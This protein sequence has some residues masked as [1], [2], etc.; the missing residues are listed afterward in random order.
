[1]ATS[2]AEKKKE[3]EAKK[4]LDIPQSILAGINAVAKGLG[5]AAVELWGIF[6]RQYFVKG[7]TEAFTAVSLGIFAWALHGTIGWWALI[8]ATVAHM[9]A[10]GAIMLLGNPKYYAIEDIAGKIEEFRKSDAM[11]KEFERYKGR[12]Y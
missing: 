10:Y 1:M 8:P 7:L 2:E 3:E 4:A 11:Y 5:V 12:N 9:F 6:V